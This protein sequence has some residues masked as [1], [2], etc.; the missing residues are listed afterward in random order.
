M[1]RSTYGAR[2]GRRRGS[3]A[4][5]TTSAAS[6]PADVATAATRPDRSTRSVTARPGQHGHLAGLEP[7]GQRGRERAHAAGGGPGAERLLQVGV[8][9]EP[10]RDVAQVVPLRLEPVPGDQAQPLVLELLAEPLVQHLTAVEDRA[11][12]L[13]Q[14][15]GVPRHLEVVATQHLPVVGVRRNVVDPALAV[16]GLEGV[17]GGDLGRPGPTGELHGRAVLEAVLADDLDGRELELLLDRA[18]GLAEEVAHDGGQQHRRRSAV[19]AEVAG[20]LRGERATEDVA[21][22]DEGH[23]VAELGQPG[24]GC[25]PA[26]AASRPP[27]PAPW[28]EPYD[29]ARSPHVRVWRGHPDAVRRAV[30]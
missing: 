7:G 4:T 25:E 5:T 20:G 19:P 9:A 1:V 10:R 18:A 27:R 23:R 12:V 11:H 3:I 22:L 24:S 26:E 28:P 17:H 8:H 15:V 29:H 13:R 21:L 14:V 16:P 30:F 6:S 2:V